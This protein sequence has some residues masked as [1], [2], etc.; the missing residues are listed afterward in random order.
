[1]VLLSTHSICFENIFFNYTLL[2]TVYICHLFLTELS[3]FS[4]FVC[5]TEIVAF[6][7]RI[8]EFKKID[9]EIVGCSVDSPHTHL[10]W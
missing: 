9:T 10:A 5:P 8:E 1:M 6:H 2:P 7:D 4:T 3:L